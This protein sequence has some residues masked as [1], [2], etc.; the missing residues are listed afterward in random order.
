MVVAFFAAFGC[1][2][3]WPQLLRSSLASS[4]GDCPRCRWPCGQAER[5]RLGGHG[6]ERLRR[7]ALGMDGLGWRHL[8][9]ARS[10][11]APPASR[12]LLGV[13]FMSC[14]MPPRFPRLGTIKH[15]EQLAVKDGSSAESTHPPGCLGRSLAGTHLPPGTPGGRRRWSFRLAVVASRSLGSPLRTIKHGERAPGQGTLGASRSH[16]TGGMGAARRCLW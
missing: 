14:P 6:P 16:P 5:A 2:H 7:V 13:P 1:T 8:A 12:L 4:R 10:G 15:D 3:S 9:R 11:T